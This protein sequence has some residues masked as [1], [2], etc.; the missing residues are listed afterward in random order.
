[1]PP[2]L[3]AVHNEDCIVGLKKL[4]EGSIDLAFANPPFNIGYLPGVIGDEG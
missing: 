2:E 4:T 3:N 1:M